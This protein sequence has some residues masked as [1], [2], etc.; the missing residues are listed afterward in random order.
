MLLILFLGFFSFRAR[1]HVVKIQRV[2][3][4]SAGLL[5]KTQRAQLLVKLLT[6]SFCTRVAPPVSIQPAS[7][8]TWIQGS[9][10]PAA[11]TAVGNFTTAGA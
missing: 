6:H 9:I 10:T 2:I 4:V 1:R 8:V 11:F 5:K 3:T 7:K